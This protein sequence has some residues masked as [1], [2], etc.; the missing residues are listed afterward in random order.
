MKLMTYNR[1][2]EWMKNGSCP[3]T[4]RIGSPEENWSISSKVRE[5]YAEIDLFNPFY[6]LPDPEI[7]DYWQ[8]VYFQH[9]LM[10]V[11]YTETVQN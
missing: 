8:F 1:F 2:G 10:L 7:L 6:F 5:F 4:N 3:A 11:H 9:C